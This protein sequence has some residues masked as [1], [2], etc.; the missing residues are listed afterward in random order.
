MLQGLDILAGVLTALI[1]G[2]ML[3]RLGCGTYCAAMLTGVFVFGASWWKFSVNADAYILAA[4][5]LLLSARAL[6]FTDERSGQRPLLAAGLF[7]CAAMLVHQLGVLFLPAVWT[8]IWSSPAR[9]RTERLRSAATYTV[10]T[11]MLTFAIYYCGYSLS[12]SRSQYGSFL[13][14]VVSH[15]AESSFTANPAYIAAATVKSYAQLLFGGRVRL[16]VQFFHPWMA[17]PAAIL[18]VSSLILSVKIW[19]SR[20]GLLSMSQSAFRQALTLPAFRISGAWFLSY[21]L[22][23]LFWLPRNTF[24]KLMLWPALILCAGC[25]LKQ[26]PMSAFSAARG[27]ALWLASQFCWN[28]IFFIYPYSRTAS[29]Q[30]LDFAEHAS[31]I[32]A[33][34]ELVLFRTF[35]TDDWTIRYFTPQIV[36]KSLG[37]GGDYCISIIESERTKGTVWLDPTAIQFLETATEGTKRWLD[38][39]RRTGIITECCGAKWPVRF[40]RVAQSRPTALRFR[41]NLIQDLRDCPGSMVHRLSQCSELSLNRSQFVRQVQTRQDCSFR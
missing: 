6:I 30:V 35:D 18:L 41:N 4:L 9:T 27:M 8:G 21:A 29:N 22:F 16:F 32:W 12:E 5:L 14:W 33:P 31:G 10:L 11:G 36:W 38:E 26:A 39:G 3:A 37:C 2:R 23:L 17:A 20:A 25:V 1:L 19:R 24:Y 13:R 40:L 7:H 28:L 15:S 34:G